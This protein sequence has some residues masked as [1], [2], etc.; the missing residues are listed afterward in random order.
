MPSRRTSPSAA[1]IADFIIAEFSALSDP[2]K[3]VPM[4]AYM[5][6]DMPFYGIPKPLRVPVYREMLKRFPPADI[7]AWR[8]NVRA[9]WELPRREDKYAAIHYA[10]H[11][12]DLLSPRDIPFL[13]RMIEEGA[14]WDLVDEIA[15]RLVGRLWLSHR[16]DVEPV[17]DQW[18]D[19]PHLWVRRSAIIGQLS[20]KK[21]TDE[22]RLYRY[23]LARAHE[24]EFFIRKAIGW[25]LRQ[26]SY[27]NPA[28][29]K[30]F[31]KNN[32]PRLS[33]LSYREGAKALVR[34]GKM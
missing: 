29:V 14:W 26:Y 30:R 16:A 27:S 25:S 22:Q 24:K 3:A 5:K 18:I 2:V 10:A 12:A 7:R 15:P 31:L 32:Q 33:G 28:G 1:P 21:H 9:L 20:H 19:D 11:F 17:M 13:K 34:T 6:T 4:A 23:C 8:A